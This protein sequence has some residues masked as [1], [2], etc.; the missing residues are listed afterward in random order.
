MQFVL[1]RNEGV[2][3][4]LVELDI[5]QYGASDVWADLGCL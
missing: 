1:Q 5:P 3:S 4:S 2:V